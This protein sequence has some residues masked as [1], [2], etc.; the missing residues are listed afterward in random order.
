VPVCPCSFLDGRRG[1]RPLRQSFHEEVGIQIC[2]RAAADNNSLSY[3]HSLHTAKHNLPRFFLPFVTSVALSLDRRHQLRLFLSTT[4]LHL[5]TLRNI[6]YRLRTLSEI[7]KLPS[8]HHY[9]MASSPPPPLQ[10]PAGGLSPCY[11]SAYH[12]RN[13]DEKGNFRHFLYTPDETHIS[14]GYWRFESLEDERRAFARGFHTPEAILHAVSDRG[15]AFEDIILCWIPGQLDANMTNRQVGSAGQHLLTILD[16]RRRLD[17]PLSFRGKL[18][19]YPIDPRLKE[20]WSASITYGSPAQTV[21]PVTQPL[22]TN[23]NQSTGVQ[24]TPSLTPVLHSSRASRVANYGQNGK[25]IT[26]TG[27][28]TKSPHISGLTPQ[29]IPRDSSSPQ[30]T[31]IDQS[32]PSFPDLLVTQDLQNASYKKNVQETQANRRP[33]SLMPQLS[34][35]PHS[36]QVVPPLSELLNRS[37]P[38]RNSRQLQASSRPSLSTTQSVGQQVPNNTLSAQAVDTPRQPLYFLQPNLDLQSTLARGATP[39]NT[40]ATSTASADRVFNGL[41][42]PPS[43][44]APLWSAY[45]PYISYRGRVSPYA[46][47]PAA[48]ATQAVESTRPQQDEVPVETY[49]EDLPM[50][51][52]NDVSVVQLIHEATSSVDSD[53]SKGPQ[54]PNGTAPPFKTNITPQNTVYDNGSANTFRN[55]T[56]TSSKIEAGGQSSGRVGALQSPTLCPNMPKIGHVKSPTRTM[57]SGLEPTWQNTK[58][59]ANTR[60]GVQGAPPARVAPPAA[61][62]ATSPE[63]PNKQPITR[64]IA[65]DPDDSLHDKGSKVDSPGHVQAPPPENASTPLK[66]SDMYP[67]LPCMDCGEESG[68]KWDCY[69]GSKLSTFF[70]HQASADSST[71]FKPKGN[72]TVLDYRALAESVALFDPGPWTTHQGPPPQPEPE[73]RLEQIRGIAEVI[74]NESSYKE[75]AQLHSL[76]DEA[77]IMLWAFKTSPNVEVVCK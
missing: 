3:D 24:H 71:D 52:G 9:Y 27:G 48:R 70:A 68:H 59:K 39:S 65:A 74:R 25:A 55:A 4:L 28:R 1:H 69:V 21:R 33:T 31:A 36:K 67:G 58:T 72:L 34:T 13:V 50:T 15:G 11:R 56:S 18:P 8:T 12:G 62:T 46:P 75:D 38:T 63:T 44:K 64:S 40:P 7:Q 47:T 19:V 32:A 26:G 53:L 2:C 43:D 37:A 77:M 10:S 42:L 23:I 5:T 60:H 16:L 66:A 49:D 35:N 41:S 29:V 17:K 57:V 22:R 30:P 45:S 6:S 54:A 61:T 73:D 51:L 20:Y 14:N 76:P